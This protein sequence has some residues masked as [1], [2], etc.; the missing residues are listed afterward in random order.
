LFVKNILSEIKKGTYNG[1]GPNTYIYNFFAN[2]G[3]MTW[4]TRFNT[5][6]EIEL[7]MLA[8][9]MGIFTG[10]NYNE[11]ATDKLRYLFTS[12]VGKSFEEKITKADYDAVRAKMGLSDETIVDAYYVPYTKEE[13]EGEFSK[14]EFAKTLKQVGASLKVDVATLLYPEEVFENAQGELE[15][16]PLKGVQAAANT[17]KAANV[18]AMTN[19]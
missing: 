7:Y 15:L 13:F 10:E 17:T 5:K 2:I 16:E 18:K 4:T 6:K 3:A 19:A 8:F 12:I 14:S 11:G 9:N 1:A